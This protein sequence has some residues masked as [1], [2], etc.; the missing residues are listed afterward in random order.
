MGES[1]VPAG[2]CIQNLCVPKKSAEAEGDRTQLWKLPTAP[3]HRQVLNLSP[4]QQWKSKFSP[5]NSAARSIY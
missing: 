5:K 1:A 4:V 3:L 2:H